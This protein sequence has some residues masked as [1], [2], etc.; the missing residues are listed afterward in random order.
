MLYS[1]QPLSLRA[2]LGL[3]FGFIL[4]LLVAVAAF[5]TLQMRRLNDDTQYVTEVGVPSL[6]AIADTRQRFEDVRRQT[7]LHIMLDSEAEMA[8]MDERVAK[9]RTLL[10]RTTQHYAGAQAS[11]EARQRVDAVNAAVAEYLLLWSRMRQLS[12]A[13]L[14]D[15][16]ARAQAQRLY[17]GEGREAYDK[18][19]SAIDELWAYEERVQKL[20]ADAAAATY[21]TGMYAATA[22]AALACVFA[23]AAATLTV[24]S[25]TRQ[26]GGEPSYASQVVARIAAGDLSL[27]V[28]IRKGD[29]Q[30]LLSA[31]EGMKVRL[32][33]A[34]RQIHVSADFVAQSSSTVAGSS[35]DL[36]QRTDEQATSLQQTAASLEQLSSSVASNA[37]SVD[38]AVSLA[39]ATNHIAIAGG[40]MMSAVV[41][42]MHDMSA[43]SRRVLE[44]TSVIDAIAFQTNI[45][46]LNAAVEAARAGEHGRGF[47]VVAAEVRTLARSSA[48]AAK[49]IKQ[50]ICESVARVDDGAALVDRAGETITEVVQK[51]SEVTSLIRQVGSSTAEQAVGIEQV[52]QAMM[53]LD[54]MT[55]RNAGLADQSVQ[56]S[57]ALSGQARALVD[58]IGY[59]RPAANPHPAPAEA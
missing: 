53:Q 59:F 45:L 41:T 2:R 21:N 5:G 40:E 6:K 26:I 30:S 52:S 33:Q 7:A 48:E 1:H 3:G 25:V 56:V 51:V 16:Q 13:K 44:I 27:Q 42:T 54:E 34:V 46:S 8:G 39:S 19:S 43:S 4:L 17:I 31:I 14:A 22:L 36:S 37:Q 55:V 29:N 58:S 50:L 24:N 20:N 11:T 47:A 15:P 10:E 28:N 38:S 49:E 23:V 9:S 12:A 32:S 57:D 18:A 35:A